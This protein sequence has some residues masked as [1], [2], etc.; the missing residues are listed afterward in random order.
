M[1][2][3]KS[4][5]LRSK[6]KKAHSLL[7]AGQP[8]KALV[9]LQKALEIGEKLVAENPDI[10]GYQRDLAKHYSYLGA[11][12]SD[13]AKRDEAAASCQKAIEIHEKIVAENPDVLKYH[14]INETYLA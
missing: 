2:S 11:V 5:L 13:T 3:Q 12:Q 7:H 10:L 1:M 6:K 9:S 8:D 14:R 4:I